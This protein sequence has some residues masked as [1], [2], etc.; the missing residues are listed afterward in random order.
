MSELVRE[1]VK[2]RVWEPGRIAETREEAP[3]TKEEGDTPSPHYS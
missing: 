2:G 1:V 3:L